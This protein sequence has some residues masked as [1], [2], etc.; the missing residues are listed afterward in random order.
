MMNANYFG[1]HGDTS[2]KLGWFIQEVILKQMW[3]RYNNPEV[4]LKYGAL[5]FYGT[6]SSNI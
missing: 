3:T 5:L 6:R 2:T 4:E 1:L